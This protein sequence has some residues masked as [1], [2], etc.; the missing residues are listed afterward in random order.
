MWEM[1]EQKTARS[2]ADGE[3]RGARV[4]TQAMDALPP[5]TGRSAGSARTICTQTSLLFAGWQESAVPWAGPE[6]P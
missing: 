4:C 2:L 6:L 3:P 5:V 1:M